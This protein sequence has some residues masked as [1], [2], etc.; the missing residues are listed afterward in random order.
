MS[1]NIHPTA[2]I[3]EGAKI[4]ADVTIGPYCIIGPNVTIGDRCKLHSHVVLDGFTTLGVENEIFPFASL[5]AEPQDLKFKGEEAR[6]IIGDRNKIREYCTMQPGTAADR[7][8]TTVGSDCL[9]MASTHVAHD[10]IVGNKVIMANCATI[11]GHVIVGDHAFL[12]GLSA[13]QQ[14]VRIGQG[15]MIGGTSGVESDVIPYGIVIGRR[16][17]LNGLN[18]VRLERLGFEKKDVRGL[19]D[20]YKAIFEKTEQTF[21]ERMKDVL[22]TP[23]T[24]NTLVEDLLT[25]IKDKPGSKLCQPERN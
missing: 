23:D 8:E 3:H 22:E 24:G 15:A 17:R 18:V 16:A 9:F 2:I 21:S 1:Q 12:G 19:Y 5:G 6:L 20:M 4:G 7:M 14:R 11:A 10:C 13:V 25:F